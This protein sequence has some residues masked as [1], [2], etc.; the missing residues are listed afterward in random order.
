MHT[1][2]LRDDTLES[3]FYSLSKQLPS[4]VIDYTLQVPLHRGSGEIRGLPLE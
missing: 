3:G 1:F 2:T 4:P